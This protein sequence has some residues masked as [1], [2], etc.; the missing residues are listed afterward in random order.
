MSNVVQF[1]KHAPSIV[2]V[3]P[4]TSYRLCIEISA[5]QIPRG[6]NRAFWMV[7]FE[8]KLYDLFESRYSVSSGANQSVV[9]EVRVFDT[10]NQTM[11]DKLQEHTDSLIECLKGMDILVH[12]LPCYISN[13]M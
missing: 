7:G 8:A 6:I 13:R 11:Q 4:D 1:Q 12:P 10:G 5:A 9:I 3:V 2:R